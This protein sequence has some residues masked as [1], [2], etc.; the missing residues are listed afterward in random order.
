MSG[1][2][3]WTPRVGVGVRP[4][5]GVG[6]VAGVSDSPALFAGGSAFEDGD[7]DVHVLP[8]TSLGLRVPLS[9]LDLRAG[10]TALYGVR[11]ASTESGRE[12]FV[13]PHLGGAVR[14]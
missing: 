7:L 10:A 11:T 13:Q 9:G 14:F 2:A 1:S 5:V 12:V 4:E 6:V 8:T 3:L